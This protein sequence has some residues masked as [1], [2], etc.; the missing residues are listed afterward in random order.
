MDFILSCPLSPFSELPDLAPGA[1][2]HVTDLAAPGASSHK[3][4]S[5]NV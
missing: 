5:I 1:G 2:S 3:R 4:P